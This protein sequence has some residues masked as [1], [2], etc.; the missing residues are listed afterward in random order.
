[1]GRWNTFDSV[2]P[3]KY[4]VEVDVPL[5]EEPEPLE[6]EPEPEP[7]ESVAPPG[8]VSVAPLVENTMFPLWSV[9]YTLRPAEDSLPRAAL[10]G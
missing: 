2:L 8:N 3:I 9:R 6:E 5:E 10:V 4:S 1:M 7:E